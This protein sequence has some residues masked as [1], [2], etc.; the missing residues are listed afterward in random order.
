M[1]KYLL[2]VALAAAVASPALAASQH[3]TYRSDSAEGAYAYAMPES[4]T[5]VSAGKIIGRDPDPA[6][7]ADLLRQGDEVAGGNN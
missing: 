1:K 3:R 2:A 7:R 6:I 4:G 5:V